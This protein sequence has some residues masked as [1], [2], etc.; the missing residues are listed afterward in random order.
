M[1]SEFLGKDVLVLEGWELLKALSGINTH[2]TK[3]TV[4]I[5]ENTQDIACLAQ[6]VNEKMKSS[7][8]HAYLIKGHGI[9]TWGKDLDECF[10]HLEALESMMEYELKRLT[11]KG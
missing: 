4:P 2:E 8:L 5:F 11:L 3:V 10:H 9:Y 1:I 7:H 6:Q